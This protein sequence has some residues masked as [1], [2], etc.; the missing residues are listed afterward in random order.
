MHSPFL[1]A[2]V[3]LTEIKSYAVKIHNL[4]MNSRLKMKTDIENRGGYER[5]LG[6]LMSPTGFVASGKF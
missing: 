4:T 2:V 6:S 3:A 5:V 1:R